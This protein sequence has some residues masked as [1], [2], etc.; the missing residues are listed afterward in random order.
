MTIVQEGKLLRTRARRT[1]RRGAT[2]Y[3]AVAAVTACAAFTA[4]AFAAAAPG[5]AVPTIAT[6]G[7]TLPGDL[8]TDDLANLANLVNTDANREEIE[9]FAAF[10]PAI[11]GAAAGP[12]DIQQPEPLQSLLATAR[13]LVENANLPENVKSTLLRVITFLDGSG[14]GG[15]AIPEDGP[16]IA[17]FLYPTVGFG[18]I[19]EE[20]NSIGAALAVP[21]PA[22]LPPPGVG[23]G[24]AGFVFT[25]LGTPIPT[26]EQP[27]PMTVTWLNLDNRRSETQ[28]LTDAAKI[29]H[30]DGPAAL[31]TI[32]D[33]GPGRVVAVISG[34]LTTQAEGEAPRSCTFLPT[35]GF[36]TVA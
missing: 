35:V 21:G 14:G 7:G 33:T 11:L 28:N 8:S 9:A 34:G 1:T 18:C 27:V 30:P 4:P 10:V 25:A 17:Q 20:G 22:L 32:A 36:F 26:A 29:N 13:E 5:D 2:R 16:V 19:S 3:V 24:Q 12:A 15:P 23:P 6:P 31:T